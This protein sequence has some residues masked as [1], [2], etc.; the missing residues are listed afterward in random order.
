MRIE[1][2]CHD[3]ALNYNDVLKSLFSSTENN[4]DSISFPQ[5]Y[6][7]LVSEFQKSIDISGLID[8]PYG[9][10]DT[11]IRLHS[12]LLAI[13]RGCKFIDLVL[14][15]SDV[16]NCRLSEIKRDVESSLR[17]CKDNRVSFRPVIEYRIFEPKKVI[18]LCNFLNRIGVDVIVTSTGTIVDDITDNIIIAREIQDN[19]GIHSIICSNIYSSEQIDI[20]SDSNIHGVR[21]TSASILKYLF[22]NGV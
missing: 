19:S 9:L 13:R 12:I 20:I 18:E 2:S 8:F 10:S 5:G 17:L 16:E 21:F 22:G 4:L 7:K 1:L 11:E 6:L 3:K 15:S 14:N